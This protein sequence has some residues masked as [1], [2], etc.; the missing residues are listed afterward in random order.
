[1]W[2]FIGELIFAVAQIWKTDSEIRDRSPMTA[3]SEFDKESRRFVARLCGV[4]IFFLFIAGIAWW[5]LTRS[6]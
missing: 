1:M 6:K 4:I 2:D 3:G 5:W